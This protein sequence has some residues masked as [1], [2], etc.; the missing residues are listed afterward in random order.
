MHAC[1]CAVAS[2]KR[3]DFVVLGGSPYIVD[4]SDLGNLRALHLPALL[5]WASRTWVRPRHPLPCT[6]PALAPHLPLVLAPHQVV[7][8]PADT[9]LVSAGVLVSARFPCLH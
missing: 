6:C 5:S 2:I 9:V 8:T 7:L 1:R 3:G 4:Q